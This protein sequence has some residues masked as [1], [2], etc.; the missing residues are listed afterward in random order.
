ADVA[1]GRP[2]MGPPDPTGSTRSRNEASRMRLVFGPGGR[3]HNLGPRSASLG[4]GGPGQACVDAPRP[5]QLYFSVWQAGV[6]PPAFV[7]T[8]GPRPD[9][10][11]E[12]DGN[13]Q[14]AGAQG[15]QPR[16]LQEQFARAGELPAASR[17]L[18][19]RLYH[20]PEEAELGPAQGR[21]GAPDH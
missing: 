19:P 8:P 18:H 3:D 16:D 20:H 21:Q 5:R 6:T 17:G 2:R 11:T 15:A 7:F 4:G 9:P 1:T 10:R 14:P 12:T 13:D